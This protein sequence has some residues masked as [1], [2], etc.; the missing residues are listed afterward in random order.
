MNDQTEI[1][2]ITK[3]WIDVAK[4]GSFETFD[5]FRS[6]FGAAEKRTFGEVSDRI[7]NPV[8]MQYD[9]VR[10][11]LVRYSGY[12]DPEDLELAVKDFSEIQNP[13]E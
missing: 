6:K 7:K 3:K 1:H 13:D 4:D 11:D 5:V 10:N 9:R 2:R 12:K 8:A